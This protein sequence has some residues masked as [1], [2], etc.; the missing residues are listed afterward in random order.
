MPMRPRGRIIG[1][2]FAGRVVGAY[3]GSLK[4]IQAT[5]AVNTF[6]ITLGVAGGLAGL[7][8]IIRELG[9]KYLDYT[10]NVT[11]YFFYVQFIVLAT[12]VVLHKLLK[13]RFERQVF[14][15]ED[16]NKIVHILSNT[17]YKN[18]R[19]D[20]KLFDTFQ[21]DREAISTHDSDLAELYRKS[22][23]I[24]EDNIKENLNCAASLFSIYTADSCCA[25]IKIVRQDKDGI[26]LEVVFRD[27]ESLV[28]K[29]RLNNYMYKVTDNTSFDDISR[30]EIKYYACDDLK[31]AAAAGEYRN[32]R[33]DWNKDY[34]ATLVLPLR[35]MRSG[36][37]AP[38]AG[39]IL[40]FLCLDNHN[41]G[42]ENENAMLLA[43]AICSR[44]EVIFHRLAVF[45]HE[46][47]A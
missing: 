39:R 7:F 42:F 19:S 38:D 16:N 4:F 1:R 3:E 17:A 46:V 5:N 37:R 23:T 43:R 13:Y 20:G 28:A 44:I 27:L 2:R 36:E 9:Q 14:R 40:G 29:N 11:E 33:P 47:S 32:A 30:G 10:L 25:C 18:S 22:K 26:K 6:L 24:V 21:A 31:A 12:V 8:S 15:S 35:S 41:G 45:E 34:N